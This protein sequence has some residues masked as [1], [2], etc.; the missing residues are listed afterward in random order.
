MT[1]AASVLD[2][3]CTYIGGTYDAARR[4]YAP[5]GGVPIVSP[6]YVTKRAK[7]KDWAANN[8]DYGA[9]TPQA[10]AA[11]AVV[12]LGTNPS[13]ERRIAVGG[14]SSGIK[15][16]CEDVDIHV[17]INARTSHAED[18][19]DAIMSCVDSMRARLRADRTCGSGG[20]EVGGFQIAETE[21]WL[22]WRRSD[23]VSTAGSSKATLLFMTEA[24]YYVFA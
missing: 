3:I 14:P 20:F 7:P 12:T 23:V 1:T 24:H 17:Y 2:T 9:A 5:V 15:Q 21:P 11:L 18:C 4:W 10:V 6:I 19:E 22:S 8:F 16:V 13:S